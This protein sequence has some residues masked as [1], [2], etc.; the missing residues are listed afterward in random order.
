VSWIIE[1][2]NERGLDFSMIDDR[3]KRRRAKVRCMADVEYRPVDWLWRDRFP[4]GRISILGGFHGSG[5]SSLTCD[6]AATISRGGVWPD[7]GLVDPGDVLMLVAEDDIESTVEARLRFHQADKSRVHILEGEHESDFGL[8]LRDLD[9]IEDAIEQAGDPR[10]LIVDPVGSFLG[11]GVDSYRDNEVRSVLSPLNRLASKHEVAVILVA[12]YRKIQPGRMGMA[13]DLILGSRAFGALSRANWHVLPDP[14]DSDRRLMVPGRQ[15]LC[16]TPLGLAFRIRDE[17]GVG[18][19]DW[20]DALVH[21]TA[22]QVLAR[23]EQST[24]ARETRRS[25]ALE[26]MRDFFSDGPKTAKEVAGFV[27]AHKIGRRLKERLI[28]ELEIEQFK[29][30]FPSV[31]YYSMTNREDSIS[32]A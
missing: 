7:G 14:A 2:H 20:E 12:H 22:D 23:M 30:G 26:A 13:D 16:K 8:T 21:E 11:G 31:T 10:C 15:S 24:G 32:L 28:K 18:V 19:V 9:L 29:E 5:K 17:S 1:I 27:S 25:Q 3:D 6:L 4:R